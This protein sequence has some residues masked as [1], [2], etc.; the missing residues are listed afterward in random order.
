ML[1]WLVPLV[2]AAK[3]ALETLPV[4][5]SGSVSDTVVTVGAATVSLLADQCPS[6]GTKSLELGAKLLTTNWAVDGAKKAL[7]A[8][9]AHPGAVPSPAPALG[10]DN[11]LR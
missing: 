7:W 9:G 5:P 4:V 10:G 2:V 3:T 1:A 6:A 8:A 11:E